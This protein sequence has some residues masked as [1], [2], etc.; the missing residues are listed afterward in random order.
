MIQKTIVITGTHHTPAIETIKQLQEDSLISWKI[1]YF[2]DL[3]SQKS[4][5]ENTIIP[6][7]KVNL[8]HIPC[9]KFSR[10]SIFR[11]LVSAPQIIIGFIKSFL[12][13]LKIKP[14]LVISFG[15][16]VSVPVIIASAL[17]RIPSVTHE[18]TTT[19]SLATQINSFF[20]NKVALSFPNTITSSP[21]YLVTGNIL[22]RQIF[23][24]SSTK[25]K[26]LTKPIIY[27]TGGNQGSSYINSQI[28]KLL[29]EL[30]KY[31]L[32]HQTGTFDY[33]KYSPLKSTNYY[34]YKF[35]NQEE[36]GWVLNHAQIVISRSGANT[37]Q[38]LAALHKKSILIPHPFTQQDEQIKNARWLQSVNKNTII[39][40]QL[41]ATPENILLAITKLSKLSNIQTKLPQIIQ[42]PLITLIHEII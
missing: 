4:H 40:P 15:G 12:Y 38:E 42:H 28:I 32:I 35:I 23:D 13:V 24:S 6:K 20:V 17:Q 5:L 7:L 22:R 34:P 19:I 1:F 2:T 10:N 8:V 27:I 16:Y 29:P 30:K 11:T 31:S 3:N 26:H 25:F 21:K 33:S 39:I 41:E 36:I 9:G 14:N 37:C 18:Q